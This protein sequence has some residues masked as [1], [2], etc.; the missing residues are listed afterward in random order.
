M[1]EG[2]SSSEESEKE[3]ELQDDMTDNLGAE[4]TQKVD[5][6]LN[7]ENTDGDESSHGDCEEKL[8]C[9]GSKCEERN[10]EIQSE[11]AE[12]GT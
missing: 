2:T 6:R 7:P 3:T 9:N 10:T 11:P 5:H 8:S 4:G 1:A 12:D